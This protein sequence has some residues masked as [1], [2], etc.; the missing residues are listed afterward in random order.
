MPQKNITKWQPKSF[1]LSNIFFFKRIQHNACDI[2]RYTYLYMCIYY[3]YKCIFF[4]PTRT[5][6]TY[7]DIHLPSYLR[8]NIFYNR[9]CIKKCIILH[10][11]V[12]LYYA[13]YTHIHNIYNII[14][15]IILQQV[16]MR[17]GRC[18][19]AIIFPVTTKFQPL[20]LI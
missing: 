15:Y 4:L 9:K 11:R 8:W 18:S 1:I 12:E 3:V 5:S 20:L 7:I 13:S 19:C 17:T 6:Y 16:A 2:I 10:K 14:I